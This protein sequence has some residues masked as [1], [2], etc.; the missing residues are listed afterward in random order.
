[1]TRVRAWIRRT[2]TTWLK[3]ATFPTHV[4]IAQAAQDATLGD[5]IA[6]MAL[7]AVL[8]WPLLVASLALQG[9]NSVLPFLPFHAPLVSAIAASLL[10]GLLG[11]PAT[12]LAMSGAIYLISRALSGHASF[13][14]QTYLLAAAAAPLA[15][16]R[17]LMVTYPSQAFIIS[18]GL[19]A[20]LAILAIRTVSAV[21]AITTLRSA[22]AVV[23]TAV[24][25]RV[26]SFV[27]VLI[28]GVL[29]WWAASLIQGP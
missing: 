11:L 6:W 18:A 24:L 22:G 3:A 5:A 27:L 12:L 21:H 4:W 28:I 17:A 26:I 29:W 2:L 16:F 15:T 10:S 14:Q 20:W 1:V 7:A 19:D 25:F 9:S 8:Q 23:V 13:T